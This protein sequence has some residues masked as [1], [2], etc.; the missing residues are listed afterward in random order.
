MPSNQTPLNFITCEV[1]RSAHGGWYGPI[2]DARI[3][4]MTKN[5]RVL[6]TPT[7]N[8]IANA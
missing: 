1:G 3:E 2:S 7:T 4:V 8:G 5:F 6:I